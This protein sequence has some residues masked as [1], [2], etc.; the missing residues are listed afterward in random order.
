[1]PDLVVTDALMPVLTG[2][3]LVEQLQ[4]DPDLRHIPI[5]M[6]TAAASPLRVR[7]MLGLGCKSVVAKP[8]DED[9]LP[10]SRLRRPASSASLVVAGVDVDAGDALAVE[11]VDVAAVVLEGEAQVEA[12]VAQVADGVLL[13][14]A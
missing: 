4:G 10:R 2:D 6:A 9:T 3:E 5:I 13:E 14:V 11:H 8:M 12:V 7:K 1:M